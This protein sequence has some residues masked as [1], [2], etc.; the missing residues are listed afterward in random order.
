MNSDDPVKMRRPII[1][2]PV[3]SATARVHGCHH[4][5]TRYQSEAL[6]L[7]STGAVSYSH[8]ICAPMIVIVVVVVVIIIIITTTTVIIVIIYAVFTVTLKGYYKCM[9][10]CDERLDVTNDPILP[11]SFSFTLTAPESSSASVSYCPAGNC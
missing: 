7:S 10:V 6:I 3:M 9:N 2:I 5:S 4:A 11:W 1:L 8:L